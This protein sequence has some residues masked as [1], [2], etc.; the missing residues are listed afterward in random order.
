MISNLHIGGASSDTVEAASLG[1]AYRRSLSLDYKDNYFSISFATVDFRDPKRNQ[2]S[3]KLE[4]FDTEWS[5]VSANNTATYTNL[6]GGKF[7]FRVR[8]SDNDGYWNDEALSF[9]LT[10]ASPPWLG[11]PAFILYFLVLAGF[12]YLVASLRGKNSLRSKITELTIVKASLE[13]ANQ[14]LADLSMMD[15]LTGIPNRRRLKE[16]L[17]SLI[18]NSAREKAPLSMLMLDLDFFKGYNDKY[19]HLAGDEALKAVARV[20]ENSIE[21]ATAPCSPVWWGR[22]EKSHQYRH[23]GGP[24]CSRA[25]KEGGGSFGNSQYE[26][27]G[28]PSCHHQRRPCLCYL[29]IRTEWR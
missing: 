26:F 18:A 9:P 14:R 10:V 2:Y 22:V 16:F 8:A 15:G 20:I 23:R 12:G 29:G 17:P 19:G 7:V 3:Y 25:D 5:P 13:E 6:P 4:G 27:N 21:R 28:F 1:S 24:H 11:A